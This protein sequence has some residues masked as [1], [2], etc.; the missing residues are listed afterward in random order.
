[1][2]IRTLFSALSAIVMTLVCASAQA[3][4]TASASLGSFTVQLFDLDPSDGIT[5]GITWNTGSV[6]ISFAQ[7]AVFH[8]ADGS[9]DQFDQRYGTSS[10]GAVSSQA[11]SPFGQAG[12]SVSGGDGFN[13]LT[14]V[15]LAATGNVAGSPTPG[16]GT[17]TYFGAY[18]A[19]PDDFYNGGTQFTLSA[20]TIAVFRMTAT[21]STSVG[22]GTGGDGYAEAS[23]FL[24]I[25]GTGPTDTGSVI[26]PCGC[27]S[28][29]QDIEDS[30]TI[31]SLSPG[32]VVGRTGV[33]LASFTNAT[34]LDKIGY[35]GGE[36]YVYGFSSIAAVPEPMSYAMLLAGLCLIG[37]VVRRRGF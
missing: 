24:R 11:T 33:L 21:L 25:R 36:A 9:L 19:A 16:G 6:A 5:P 32:E 34:I 2:R 30:L 15:T 10:F 14:G 7:S 22:T 4:A 18:S 31:S 13:P 29:L 28:G 23:G 12:A 3:A 26:N 37:A 20:N 17:Y 35:V 1:M 27:G 8:D